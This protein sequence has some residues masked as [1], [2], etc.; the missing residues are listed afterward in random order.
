MSF[1]AR[2]PFGRVLFERYGADAFA[3]TDAAFGAQVFTIPDQIEFEPG[4][5]LRNYLNVEAAFKRIALSG[6]P[7]ALNVAC[8]LGTSPS[9]ATQATISNVSLGAVLNNNVRFFSFAYGGDYGASNLVI[10]ASTFAGVQTN[11]ANS[12]IDLP[13]AISP[14]IRLYSRFEVTTAMGFGDQV[15]LL[16]YRFT[17][18]PRKR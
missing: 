17:A 18:Y 8:R 3:I 14:N 5:F 4:F 6:A 2:S 11:N 9:F 16:F 12:I 10:T 1:F 13:A 15:S 7:V